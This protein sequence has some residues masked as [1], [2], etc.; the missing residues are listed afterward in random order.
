ME[1]KFFLQLPVIYVV[2]TRENHALLKRIFEKYSFLPSFRIIPPS[3][4]TSYNG[5][6]SGATEWLPL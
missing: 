1:F 5:A 3:H 2:V 6:Y 4:A